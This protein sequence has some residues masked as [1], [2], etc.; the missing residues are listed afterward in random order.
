MALSAY[1]IWEVRT[2]GSD[3]NGGGFKYG[4][5]GTDYSQQNSPQYS[6]TD[7]E[8][9]ATDNT[10][11][12]STTAGS[13]IAADVGNYLRISGGSGFTQGWYEII[14]QDGTWWTLDSSVGGTSLSGGTFRVGGALASP[15]VAWNVAHNYGTGNYRGFIWIAEG[16]Y[17]ITSTS[18]SGRTPASGC[19]IYGSRCSAQGYNISLGRGVVPTTKPVLQA[20]GSHSNYLAYPAY[21]TS[22][23][24]NS[25]GMAYLAF[26]TNNQL[27]AQ[28]V[29]SVSEGWFLD[30]YGS[31]SNQLVENGTY[32][33]CNFYGTPG[34]NRSVLRTGTAYYSYLKGAFRAN[35]GNDSNFAF[36][37]L[38]GGTGGTS[39]PAVRLGRHNWMKG[40]RMYTDD[41]S[42]MYMTTQH[43][44]IENNIFVGDGS[45]PFWGGGTA[46][47][48][49]TYDNLKI[50]NNYV[51]GL[52]HVDFSGMQ[53]RFGGI[54]E[55]PTALS[56]DP[57]VDVSTDDYTLDSTGSDYNTVFNANY[58]DG[59]VANTTL[60]PRNSIFT[61]GSGGTTYTPAASAKFTRLE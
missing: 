13:P 45:Q 33:Y 58:A 8:S 56:Q 40:N 10:K 15:G 18:I 12:K 51:Y 46:N 7:L 20:Q 25:G 49:F 31:T 6:G 39:Y 53:S 3:L 38:R 61:E 59:K 4:A 5:T 50:R 19:Y 26:D 55:S 23:S 36:C 21:S 54:V 34:T 14:S 17:G 43:Q 22:A 57:Y 52:N 42:A 35:C 9:D 32:Y 48:T 47:P 1:G 27:T 37:V 2:T 60:G 30:V 44:I 11:V 41:C 16:T 28:A 29:R 24:Y